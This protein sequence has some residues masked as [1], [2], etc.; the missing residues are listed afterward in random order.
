[1]GS[2]S[3]ALANNNTGDTARLAWLAGPGSAVLADRNTG[4]STRLAGS[5][6]TGKT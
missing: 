3:L 1:M 6:S 4:D 5:C 2:G